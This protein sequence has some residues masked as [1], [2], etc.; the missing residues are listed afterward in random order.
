MPG[1]GP[2]LYRKKN[3]WWFKSFWNYTVCCTK[4]HH[5]YTSISETQTNY[6]EK[7]KV[8]FLKYSSCTRSVPIIRR[9]LMLASLFYLLVQI[10]PRANLRA[11][12]IALL[13]AMS[14]FFTC[15]LLSCSGV[16]RGWY[17]L[18]LN[19][20]C[21]YCFRQSPNFASMVPFGRT[22]P[23]I[24]HPLPSSNT[25]PQHGFRTQS[26]RGFVVRCRSWRLISDWRWS[27]LHWEKAQKGKVFLS[28]WRWWLWSA[29][30]LSVSANY[31]KICS[32]VAIVGLAL[33]FVEQNMLH[34]WER[35]KMFWESTNS[36]ILLYKIGKLFALELRN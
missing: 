2:L 29:I 31:W 9:H 13:R 25:S 34:F 26:S 12:I 4:H 7:Q 21:Y 6:W 36:T 14:L 3:L 35:D 15:Y 11:K 5:Y 22:Q 30:W 27:V 24:S 19:C 32:K 33:V 8:S 28:G 10:Q 18:R 23:N 16:S 17:I 20:F 1:V